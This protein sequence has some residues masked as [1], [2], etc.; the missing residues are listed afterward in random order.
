M[1]PPYV[2]KLLVTKASQKLKTR[3]ER[4]SFQKVDFG[5]SIRLT[6]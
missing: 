3:L 5:G 4:R 2:G 1:I 6:I